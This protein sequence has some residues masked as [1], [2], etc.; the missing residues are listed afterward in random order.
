MIS[1]TGIRSSICQATLPGENPNM[2]G[3]FALHL[4]RAAWR[5]RCS[6]VSDFGCLWRG[7]L[8]GGK[9]AQEAAKQPRPFSKTPSGSQIHGWHTFSPSKKI[10]ADG[11]KKNKYFCSV[12]NSLTRTFNVS[13]FQY[14]LI[15]DF[16]SCC[17][18]VFLFCFRYLLEDVC[19]SCIWEL[20]YANIS[21]FHCIE[22]LID[23]EKILSVPWIRDAIA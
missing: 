12:L 7:L 6:Q 11:E 5:E 18:L 17:L 3:L 13:Q 1:S 21:P 9:L 15:S 16:L 19:L 14:Q 2:L 23:D 20:K 22:T 4:G 8:P 10:S